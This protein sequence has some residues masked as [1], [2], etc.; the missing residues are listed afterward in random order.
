MLETVFTRSDGGQAIKKN[1]WLT[2][3]CFSLL[4]GILT[5]CITWFKFFG[6][7]SVCLLL[8]LSSQLPAKKVDSWTGVFRE[9]I[10]HFFGSFTASLMLWIP[11]S[12]SFQGKIMVSQHLMTA[13]LVSFKEEKHPYLTRIREVLKSDTHVKLD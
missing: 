9:S 12:V 2:Y 10:C 3:R 7:T 8:D 5:F 1:A 11:L 6:I 13:F 4:P